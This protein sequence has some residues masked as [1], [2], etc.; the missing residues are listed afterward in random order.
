MLKSSV[1]N[2]YKFIHLYRGDNIC[3]LLFAFLHT[4]PLL[5]GVFS[6]RKEFLPLGVPVDP[7]SEKFFKSCD[8]YLPESVSIPK[9]QKST[10]VLTSLRGNYC[11]KSSAVHY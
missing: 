6:K 2:L 1:K 7:F 11:I 3:N 4:K 10:A 8:S 9:S 5:K